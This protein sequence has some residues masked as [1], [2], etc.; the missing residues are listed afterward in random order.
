MD[1]NIY[2]IVQESLYDKQHILGLLLSIELYDKNSTC[3]VCC[4]EEIK[5]YIELFPK[6]IELNLDFGIKP[7]NNNFMTLEYIKNIFNSLKYCINNYKECVFI[8]KELIM[9]NPL[10]ISDQIKSQGIGFIKKTINVIDK[11]KEFQRY[12]IGLLYI[13]DIECINRLINHYET[14]LKCIDFFNLSLDAYDKNK[15]EEVT[16]LCIKIYA[17]LPLFLINNLQIN[18]FFDNYTYLGTEDFFAYENSIKLTD[19]EKNISIKNSQVSFCNI[20]VNTLDKKIQQVNNYFLN[21][22]VNKHIIYMSLLNLKMSGNKLQFIIPKR[23][24]VGIWNRINDK[25]GLY[26]LID[27]FVDKNKNYISK[28]EVDIDYFSFG[29]YLLTDKPSHIWLN[30]TIKKYTGLLICNYDKSLTDILHSLPISS[31]FLFYYSYFPTIL[32]TFIKTNAN[33]SDANLYEKNIEYIRVIKNDSPDN[34]T[35]TLIYE[36]ENNE[37]I[38]EPIETSVNFMNLLKK[39]TKVKYGIIETFDINLIATYMALGV[40]P[41]IMVNENKIIAPIYDLTENV[42]YLIQKPTQLLDNYTQLQENCLTYY[43]DHIQPDVCLRKLINLI[44]V[45][46][47]Q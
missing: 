36:M 7:V 17:E 13:K 6:T 45:R 28:V 35:F 19:I 32:D 1:K 3:V 29:N 30:N 25:G 44:F 15:K 12:S 5:K 9:T 40:V 21:I 4:D 34:L 11:E 8:N 33:S 39:L 41:I 31:E 38:I 24:G 27:F 10:I 20:R 26:E 37:E 22:L 16:N 14:E 46:N 23:N 18:Y 42:H 2:C 47:I 43:N